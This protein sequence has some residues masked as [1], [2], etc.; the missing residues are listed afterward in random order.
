LRQEPTGFIAEIQ[1]LVP[2][3]GKCNQSKGNSDWR[4]WM[5]GNAKLCPRVRCIADIEERIA[6]LERFEG[7][8][9]PTKLDI[10]EI[11]G[12]ELWRQYRENWRTLLE[13]MRKSQDLAT[14]LK[15]KLRDAVNG[16]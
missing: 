1:N 2:A 8:R 10:A 4:T 3:C 11:V 13:S 14:T 5:R 15:A 7:W 6:R 16:N 9:A 12:A